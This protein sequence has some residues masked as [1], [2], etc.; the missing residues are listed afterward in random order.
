MTS[1]AFSRC[2][3]RLLPLA[4]A[5]VLAV[6]ASA[7]TEPPPRTATLVVNT[8]LVVLDV[9][10]TDR[11]G[12]PVEDLKRDDFTVFEDGKPQRIASFEPP[13]S[14]VLPASESASAD[15][16]AVFDPAQPKAF[17]QS[18]VTE[19]VLD[20]LNTHFADSSFARRSLTDYLKAQPALLTEPTVLLTVYDGHFA[21]V[22][23]YTRDR[24]ALLKALS[25]EPTH[26]AWKLE[27]LGSSEYGPLERLDQSLRALEQI[28]QN[29]ARIPGRKNVIWVG[30]G[31][32]TLDHTTI[33]GQDIH[34]VQQTIQHV[35]NTL[36]D[37][38][39]TFY[40][41]DPT[42]TLP[43]VQEITDSTQ[44]AFVEALSDSSAGLNALYDSGED[45]NRLAPI[46]GG[47]IIRGRN[48]IAQQ[49]A[50]AVDLG[51]SFYTIGYTPLSDSETASKFR[52]IRVDCKRAGLTLR[53][54]DGYFP[55]S[56]RQKIS[57][58][59]ES[60]S[61]DLT[62]AAAS[63]V[64]L[65]GLKVAVQPASSADAGAA[66]PLSFAV[67]V[68]VADLTWQPEEDGSSEA[69]VAILA[70]YLDPHGKQ[71]GHTLHAMVA[72]ARAGANLHDAAKNADFAFSVDA[73]PKAGKAATLRFVVRDA[74]TGRMG[75]TDLPAR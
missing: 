36:Q 49:I 38:H 20:Q 69:S 4:A 5:T 42:S 25:K 1:T 18:P 51:H 61:Y 67:H 35:T 64:P 21:V 12:K 11:N 26:Y 72:H 53:T 47:R 48:D 59:K 52:R 55:E 43:T 10:V 57:A 19:L 7:Q 60:I 17:G 14:H 9:V 37:T 13:S 41:I 40:A 65:N 27:T 8:R 44:A 22:H 71:L 6:A 30:A 73:A 16:A 34:E 70:V 68:S 63:S 75:S 39:V 45:F 24:E 54:R 15:L 23:P 62:A 3:F 29:G 56:D 50:Q 74:A 46:T 28:A 32:P 33:D 66:P 2:L 31:F 58:S